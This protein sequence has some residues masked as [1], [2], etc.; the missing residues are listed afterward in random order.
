MQTRCHYSVLIHKQA[1]KY[2][3]RAALIYREFG[4]LKWKECSWNEFS[5]NVRIVS[6]AMLN[7]GVKMWACSRRTRCIICL[8]T[9]VPSAFVPSRCLSMLRV[10]SSRYSL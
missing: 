2:G 6:N 1:E 3:D 8:R 5:K 10:R 7:M 9:L 4:S